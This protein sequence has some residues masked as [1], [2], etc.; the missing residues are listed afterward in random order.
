MP[1]TSRHRRTMRLTRRS[2]SVGRGHPL[3]SPRAAPGLFC[4]ARLSR[5]IWKLHPAI[6]AWAERRLCSR[7]DAAAGS[8]FSRPVHGIFQT[9]LP[10]QR[11][12]RKHT[13]ARRRRPG[14]GVAARQQMRT[15]LIRGRHRDYPVRPGQTTTPPIMSGGAESAGYG[16]LFAKQFSLSGCAR[17]WRFATMAKPFEMSL[18]R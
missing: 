13:G 4:R 1:A 8:F 3:T 6:S 15:K 11:C 5:R 12:F 7:H 17:L 10:R 16:E 2:A 18:A 14:L 9:A